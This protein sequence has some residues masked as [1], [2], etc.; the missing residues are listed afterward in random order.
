[1]TRVVAKGTDFSNADM[2]QAILVFA[3]LSRSNFTGANLR[4]AH[5]TAAHRAGARGLRAASD[6]TG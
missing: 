4:Q 3:D 2:R 1:M 6:T 5:L